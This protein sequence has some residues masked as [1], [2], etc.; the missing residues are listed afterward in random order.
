V[1]FPTSDAITSFRVVAAGVGGALGGRQE[2]AFESSL[3]LSMNVKLPVAVSVKD[4]LRLPLTLTN[5]PPKPLPVTV[6]LEVRARAKISS[7]FVR[8]STILSASLVG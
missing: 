6:Q 7:A 2:A 1:R 4:R 3:P 8:R 5:D